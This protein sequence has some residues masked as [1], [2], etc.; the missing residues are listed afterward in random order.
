ME[1]GN[2]IRVKLNCN[3]QKELSM[4][5]EIASARNNTECNDPLSERELQEANRFCLSESFW[6]DFVQHYWNKKPL[7]IRA[8]FQKP[9]VTE[10]ELFRIMCHAS[11]DYRAFV[12][13]L[14][15]L[16]RMRVSHL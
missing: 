3:M 8:P 2:P 14:D 10:D 9:L 1:L 11:D 15:V 7:L 5:N 13:P 12:R 4:T 16:D 6:A